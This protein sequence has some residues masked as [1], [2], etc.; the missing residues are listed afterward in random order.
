V[1]LEIISTKNL[2]GYALSNQLNAELANSLAH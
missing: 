2:R 1:R